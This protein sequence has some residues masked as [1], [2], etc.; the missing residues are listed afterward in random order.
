MAVLFRIRADLSGSSILGSGPQWCVKWEGMLCFGKS[1]LRLVCFPRPLLQLGG[2]RR[3]SKFQRLSVNPCKQDKCQTFHF[4]QPP[5]QEKV[6]ESWLKRAPQSN[7]HISL[8]LFF[9]K[10][11]LSPFYNWIHWIRQLINWKVILLCHGDI[12]MRTYIYTY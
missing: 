11:K 2:G 1:N 10:H 5:H 12:C 7:P 8:F 9:I 4:Q 6:V 3:N